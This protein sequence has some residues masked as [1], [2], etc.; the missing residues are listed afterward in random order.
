MKKLNLG[1]LLL[2]TISTQAMEE[3][4]QKISIICSDTTDEPAIRK[5][6]WTLREH[7]KSLLK[8]KEGI[9]K[10]QN[11]LPILK[12]KIDEMDAKNPERKRKF[13]DI[14]RRLL[15]IPRMET[16]STENG[17][18]MQNRLSTI[19]TDLENP[20]HSSERECYLGD[21]IACWHF[22]NFLC[23]VNEEQRYGKTGQDN[24]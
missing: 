8:A 12:L 11:E 4:P 22:I 14:R 15:D 23:R 13:K 3:M 18:K 2:A 24:D 9:E 10:C 21:N 19:V 1:F 17:I 5:T 20:P 7:Y 16:S 6:C